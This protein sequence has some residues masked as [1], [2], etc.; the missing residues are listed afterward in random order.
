MKNSFSHMLFE[1]LQPYA[2][3]A[4]SAL[5]KPSQIELKVW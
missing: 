1:P 4:I 5:P 2:M 3:A